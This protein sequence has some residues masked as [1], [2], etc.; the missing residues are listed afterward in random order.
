MASVYGICFGHRSLVPSCLWGIWSEE[1]LIPS[2]T[3]T[4]PWDA[5]LQPC[6]HVKLQCHL[7]VTRRPAN[8]AEGKR[9]GLIWPQDLLLDP[10]LGSFLH[11]YESRLD[12]DF[13]YICHWPRPWSEN[14]LQ[15]SRSQDPEPTVP[16]EGSNPNSVTQ[17]SSLV[18]SGSTASYLGPIDH[19][20]NFWQ[21]PLL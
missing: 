19:I 16:S 3:W 20:Q 8:Q 11:L 2:C 18:L 17:T 14:F 12:G 1:Q 13:I 7:L 21:M 6:P 9:G 10:T 15:T 4:P 5:S